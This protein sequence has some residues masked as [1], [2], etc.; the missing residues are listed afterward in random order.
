[1]AK[2]KGLTVLLDEDISAQI[3]IDLLLSKGY[4]AEIAIKGQSDHYDIRSRLRKRPMPL[5]FTKDKGWLKAG[6]VPRRHGGVV[7]FQ[8]GHL[9]ESE[10]ARMVLE[11]LEEL[12]QLKRLADSMVDRRFLRTRGSVY[13][14][15]PDGTRTKLW[16]PN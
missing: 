7:V 14:Y 11:Q 12:E 2:A 9:T 3:I 16:P 15:A 5:F 8:G 4:K 13:E 6:A 1:M 10:L